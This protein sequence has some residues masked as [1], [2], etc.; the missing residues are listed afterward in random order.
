MKKKRL[1]RVWIYAMPPTAY[2]FS[3]NLC[4][5]TDITWSEW[6]G[7]IYCYKCKKDVVG[8]SI[9]DAPIPFETS[10]LFGISFDRID[11]KTGKRLYMKVKDDKI[12]WVKNP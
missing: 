7:H 10:K 1:K 2:D 4:H 6:E 8:N 3:C 5:G 9:F 12:V 11:L